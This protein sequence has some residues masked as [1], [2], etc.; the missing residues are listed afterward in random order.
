MLSQ[1]PLFT[2][3]IVLMLNMWGSGSTANKHN[4]KEMEDIYKGMEILK[5]VESRWHT[6][7]RLWDML[8]ELAIVGELPLPAHDLGP[9]YHTLLQPHFI[10]DHRSSASRASDSAITSR[11]VSRGQPRRGSVPHS[12]NIDWFGGV[13]P[14]GNDKL[15]VRSDELGKMPLHPVFDTDPTSSWAEYDFSPSVFNPAPQAPTPHQDAMTV[16]PALDSIFTAPRKS[17]E[18]KPPITPLPHIHAPQ[19]VSSMIAPSPSSLLASSSGPSSQLPSPPANTSPS[20]PA[21]I[22]AG[23]SAEA[24]SCDR[25]TLAMWSQAP[26]G[27]E[28]DDWGNYITNFNAMNTNGTSGDVVF[29]QPAPSFVPTDRVDDTIYTYYDNP[30]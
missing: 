21:Q 12:T 10:Q 27:F 18:F 13:L 22:T 29:A 16:D 8:Y 7:G 24:F 5:S 1:I 30:M 17:Q 28:W 26:V 3:T 19:P 4:M 11:S 9:G 20:F 25:D 23:P 14:D 2:S 15:P 6:A